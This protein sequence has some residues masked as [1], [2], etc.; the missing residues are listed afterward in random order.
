[1]MN[2]PGTMMDGM[3]GMMWAMGAVWLLVAIL[4]V[5]GIAALVKYLFFTPV[6]RG[7]DDAQ[8]RRDRP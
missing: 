2:A 7:R 8:E 5:L 3:G 6:P 1:M 4:L